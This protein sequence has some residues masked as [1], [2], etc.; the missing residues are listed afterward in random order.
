MDPFHINLMLSLHAAADSKA[1]HLTEDYKIEARNIILSL[2]IFFLHLNT[3][4]LMNICIN[5][6]SMEATIFYNFKMVIV[7]SF[8]IFTTKCPEIVAFV[9]Y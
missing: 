7:N 4:V 8:N 6:M 5:H 9:V 1:F 2:Y 3:S